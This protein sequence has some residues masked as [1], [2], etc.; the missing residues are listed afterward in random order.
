[1]TNSTPRA[2]Y[3][4]LV[5]E[6]FGA[7]SATFETSSTETNP[8]IGALHATDDFQ[9]F[10]A[11]F[12]RRLER[13]GSV[14]GGSHSHRPTLLKAVNEIAYANNWHGAAA[15]VAALD[16]FLSA[17]DFLPDEPELD[18]YIDGQ[19]TF[20]RLLGHTGDAN[21][22]LHF[23]EYDCFTDVKCLKD[24]VK[25]LLEGIYAEAFS[26]PAPSVHLEGRLDMDPDVVRT[27]R[28]ALLRELRAAVAGGAKPPYIRSEVVPISFRLRWDPG[29][30]VSE[31]SYSPYR[32]AREWQRLPFG[33]A[34]KFVRDAYCFIT[35]VSFPW[36]NGLITDFGDSNRI[37]YRSMARR[38]FMQHRHDNR[39]FSELAPKF[40]GTETIHE[41]SQVL[42]GILFLE[43]DAILGANPA[44][45]NVRGYYYGNPNAHKRPHEAG[46]VDYLHSLNLKAFDDFGNDNY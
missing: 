40:Q 2:T 29:V 35:F 14:Y 25:E 19:R 24:N 17:R 20:H 28:A 5:D 30:L 42:G 12:R 18:V 13:L 43:D 26:E 16:Y 32:H 44:A 36:F 27:N 1:M 22:D 7:G 21:L 8:I 4:Q 41:V 3:S 31:G 37:F 34:K 23:A 11:N 39:S 45:I 33:H 38:V 10:R 46:F 9:Q 6:I 15:E